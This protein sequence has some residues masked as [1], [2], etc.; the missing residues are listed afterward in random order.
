MW[1]EVRH[2]VAVLP[3]AVLASVSPARGEE[4]PG[5]ARRYRNS[6]LF[7]LTLAELDPDAQDVWLDVYD[8]SAREWRRW[9]TFF[10][11]RETE[12]ALSGGLTFRAP[13]EGEYLL[14]AVAADRAGNVADMGTGPDSADLVAIYDATPPVVDVIEPAGRRSLAPGERF[15]LVWRTRE[16]H[17]ARGPS[18]SVEISADA[19]RTWRTIA[20]GMEDTGSLRLRAPPEEGDAMLRVTVWDACGNRGEGVS[21]VILVRKPAAEKR[22]PSAAGLIDTSPVG[23]LKREREDGA[24]GP[25]RATESL[26]IPEATRQQAAWARAR[27]AEGASS[28]LSGWYDEAVSRLS[29]AV[30]AD[31]SFEEAWLDYSVALSL[32]GKRELA[33]K[34][35]LRAESLFP[36]NANL[37]YNR[38]LVLVRAGRPGDAR[39]A[40]ERARHVDPTHAEAHWA[41]SVLA[42]EAGDLASARERWRD[43]VRHASAESPYRARSVRYLRAAGGSAQLP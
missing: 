28:L 24:G 36:R 15:R 18:L 23:S 41:L 39:A 10:I 20:S 14:R 8:T 29:E 12:R 16:A 7:A 31:P 35:L 6:P 32:A 17:P 33:E 25:A 27:Y 22:G 43:V 30:A 19:G 38:G 4:T 1:G 5:P 2:L 9:D 26:R 40:F 21:D 34:V 13:L 37:P 11:R 3:L 42:V